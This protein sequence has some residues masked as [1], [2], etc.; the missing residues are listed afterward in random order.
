MARGRM[1][2][3]KV[4]ISQKVAQLEEVAGP[5][6]LVFH[7]RLIAFLDKN[8]NCRAEPYWLKG[9]IMPR[10]AGCSPEDCR[11]YV[12]G[13]VEVGLAVL[14]EVDGMPYL[15]MPGF[16]EEQVGLRTDRESPD[17]PVPQGFDEKAGALPATFRQPSGYCRAEARGREHT[18]V[19][20][21]EGEVEVEGEVEAT[22][23][24]SFGA[25]APPVESPVEPKD[26][27][28]PNAV[29]K[30][31]IPLIREHLWFGKEPPPGA[32]EK[33]PG[34]DMGRESGIV[35][36]W[37]KAGDVE[38]LEE[39]EAV[40]RYARHALDTDNPFSLLF[41][42]SRDHRDRFQEVLQYARRQ[43]VQE[44]VKKRK[45]EG[46]STPIGKDIEEVVGGR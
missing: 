29:R 17:V 7:H 46:H 33:Q 36:Q 45:A 31:V 13:L 21:R 10:V 1:L 26:D 30:A 34:W 42:H 8:G 16:R 15:H 19:G 37:L 38:D 18:A 40:I 23:D 11:T 14:Y 32:L 3:R 43:M 41:L 5:Y 6:A 28:D 2:N 20:G 25:G 35:I 4:S 27:I 39:A 24:K 9:E 12:A 22:N 44:A